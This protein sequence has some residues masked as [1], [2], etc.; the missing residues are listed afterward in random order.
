[1][2]K[3]NLV[4]I[5]LVAFSERSQLTEMKSLMKGAEIMV[6]PEV[7]REAKD[8]KRWE[9]VETPKAAPATGDEGK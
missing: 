5:K 2:A 8:S 6:P 4:K 3:N 1:M 7:A 9:I